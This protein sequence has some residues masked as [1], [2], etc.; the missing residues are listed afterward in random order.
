MIESAEREKEIARGA[1][2]RRR[3]GITFLIYKLF[4]HGTCED[5]DDNE[6]AGMKYK[7]RF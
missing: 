1:V 3:D 4:G 5:N 6:D 2:F 7:M